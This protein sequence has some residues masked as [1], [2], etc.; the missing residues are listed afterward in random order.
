M[1]LPRIHAIDLYRVIDT[2]WAKIILSIGCSDVS[3][4]QTSACWI[5]WAINEC[6]ALV[7]EAAAAGTDAARP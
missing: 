1:K 4:L 7:E 3:I 6:S 2:L 5:A